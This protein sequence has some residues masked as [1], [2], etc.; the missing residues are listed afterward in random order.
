MTTQLIRTFAE[1]KRTAEMLTRTRTCMIATYECASAT[2]QLVI[3]QLVDDSRRTGQ[4]S[5]SSRGSKQAATGAALAA[6]RG[7]SQLVT[8]AHGIQTIRL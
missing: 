5:S 8:N 6:F 7:E 1:G 2:Q 3:V 4:R